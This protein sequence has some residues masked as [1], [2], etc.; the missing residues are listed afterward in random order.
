MIPAIFILLLDGSN[1]FM[2]DIVTFRIG[3]ALSVQNIFLVT[4]VFY[5]VFHILKMR[6]DSKTTVS[7]LPWFLT[8]V[9][10]CDMA[11][12][13]RRY[14]LTANWQVPFTLFLTPAL[15]YWGVLMGRTWD[16]D[17]EYFVSRMIYIMALA[18]M[19]EMFRVFRIF[20]FSEDIVIRMTRILRLPGYWRTTISSN[21]M[22]FFR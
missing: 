15:Y 5:S 18:N 16:E 9:P 7:F 11:I 14:G 13:A 4:I 2:G 22:S 1:F 19:M 8:I 6:Y 20:T 3:I 17:K 12:P 21:L 10:A